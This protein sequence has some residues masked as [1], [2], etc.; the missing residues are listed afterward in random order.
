MN[1]S[2]NNNDED[3]T[4][5]R[6]SDVEFSSTA[7]GGA[8]ADGMTLVRAVL[9]PIVAGAIIWAWPNIA[10]AC[11]ASVLFALGALT[12][13]FDDLLGGSEKAPGRA[14]GWFDDIA[15]SILIGAAL[16][17][18]LYVTDK[19]GIL[20]WAFGVPAIIYICRDLIVAA[21][22]G[23]EF[24]KN[25][26][27]DSKIGD[28]KNIAAMIGVSLLIASPWLDMVL[29]RFRASKTDDMMALYANPSPWIW[30]IGQGFLWLAAILS[31]YTAV[32]YF[33]RKPAANEA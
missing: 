6:E 18:L 19:A 27:P 32:K 29:S 14:F 15:D 26:I 28:Y 7:Q 21:I 30:Q 4:A 13:W 2:T 16:I 24:S 9:A 20:G 12:D 10:W 31:V 8:L 1:T 23:F 11:L 17:A 33:V 3:N 25:G 22:K 5:R